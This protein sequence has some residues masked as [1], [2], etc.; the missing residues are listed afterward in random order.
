MNYNRLLVPTEQ[1]VEISNH[2]QGTFNIVTISRIK[3]VLNQDILRQ[4]LDITQAVNPRLN[5]RIVGSSDSLNFIN[6]GTE[7]IPLR[8]IKHTKDENWQDV[9]IEELNNSID[10]NKCLLRCV[11]IHHQDEILKK[12]LITTV[13][14]AVSDG[15]SCISL[16]AEIFKYCQ[17]IESGNPLDFDSKN[18][19]PPL[20]EL[21]PQWMN[22]NQGI[23]KAKLFLLKLKLQMLLH[24]PEILESEETV[25]IE[26]RSCG[27][28]QQCLEKEL[29]RKL[30]TLSHQE[31]T[32]VHG[33]LCAATL[34]TVAN[35]I[36]MGKSR[37]IN[38]SCRSYIDLR[39]RIE[40]AIDHNNMGFLASFLT[41]FHTIKQQLS[42]WNLARDVTKQIEL[43]LKRKD[44][45][46]PLILFRK[47]VEFYVE[48]PDEALIT[49]SITN[50]G[51]VNIQK[52]YGNFEVEEISFV[53]SI[54]IFGR[55]V[56][57]AVTTFEEK[58]LLNF[59]VSKPSISQETMESLANDVINCITEVCRAV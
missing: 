4:A 38:L 47:I 46:K 54:S 43:G 45:F 42:F 51:K 57:V 50:V 56:T 7:K 12:Y 23:T 27:M 16:Q 58:M 53:P 59:I 39:R 28:T 32:T 15:L 14:H 34:I 48:R 9:L 20:D 22:Q 36:R 52:N 44:M 30:V 19:L 41:S 17:I 5:S 2:H 11:L 37:S 26:L 8:V 35:K 49:V 1:S 40:P 24:K 21:L 33:A 3:G 25:P 10:S 18:V 31:N 29:T 6:E 55:S 13:H